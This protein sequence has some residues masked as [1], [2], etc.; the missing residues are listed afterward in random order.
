MTALRGNTPKH[1]EI[2]KKCVFNYK[3]SIKREGRSRGGLST[4][5]TTPLYQF[6]LRR[7]DQNGGH[8]TAVSKVMSSINSDATGFDISHDF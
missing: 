3:V 4:R 1:K 2:V 5:Y 6:R 8:G 7:H